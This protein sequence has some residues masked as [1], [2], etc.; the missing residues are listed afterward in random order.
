L[1]FCCKFEKLLNFEICAFL[2][3]KKGLICNIKDLRKKCST[4]YNN[5]DQ[6]KKKIQNQ[7]QNDLKPIKVELKV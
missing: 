3:E 1:Q 6:K 5:H 2:K 7:N 4:K